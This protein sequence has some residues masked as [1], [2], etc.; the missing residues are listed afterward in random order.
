MGPRIFPGARAQRFAYDKAQGDNQRGSVLFQAEGP[1]ERDGETA[2]QSYFSAYL[3]LMFLVAR[4]PPG[5]QPGL[6]RLSGEFPPLTAR[7][8]ARKESHLWRELLP[9][10]VHANIADANALVM[11]R[12][13]LVNNALS[14]LRELWT[15]QPALFPRLKRE[16]LCFYLVG[17]SDYPGCGHPLRF[18]CEDSLVTR[19]RARI[20]DEPDR[21]FASS[22]VLP[23]PD[24]TSAT[25]PAELALFY[26]A[27]HLPDLVADYYAYIAEPKGD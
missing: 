23:A 4:K 5:A 7:A 26:S 19:L 18:P 17:G 24:E 2:P 3:W 6:Q 12:R 21:E 22:I 9:V 15:E 8:R 25:R 14:L 20:A 11:H 13:T 27:C 16:E 10:Y 1:Q